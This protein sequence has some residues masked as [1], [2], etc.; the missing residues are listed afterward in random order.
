VVP[1]DLHDFFVG[2][3]GVAGALIGLLFVAISV[4]QQ[5]LAGGPDTHLHRVRASA[6]LTTFTN[7]LPVSLLALIPGE[8]I[9]PAALVLGVLGVG[10]VAASLLSM[11]RARSLRWRDARDAVFV[12]GLLVIFSIQ[13]V[14]GAQVV[15]HPNRSSAV[16]TIAILVVVCFLVGI[17]RA[18]ELI[19][20][21]SI[22]L[23]HELGALARNSDHE[24]THVRSAETPAGPAGGH[25]RQLPE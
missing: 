22:G 24:P 4:S 13:L 12:V 5:R 2:S 9:G 18:W 7:A 10:F 6:A 15:A 23:R 1:D 3:A 19:G 11:L 25:P 14:D 20:G 8:R 16:N 17:A 21:P